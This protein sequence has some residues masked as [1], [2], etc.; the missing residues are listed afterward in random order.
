MSRSESIE[1]KVIQPDAVNTEQ[2]LLLS[3]GEVLNI[4]R[5]SENNLVVDHESVSRKHATLAW[6]HNSI[7]I[8][9]LGSRNGT[10][11]NDKLLV[12]AKQL[13]T[14]DCIEV[15]DIKIIILNKTASINSETRKVASIDAN[16]AIQSRLTERTQ[17]SQLADLNQQRYTTKKAK[18]SSIRK[19]FFL[20][21]GAALGALLAL[22]LS[23][24]IAD[25]SL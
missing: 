12:G 3:K 6:M 19:I 17:I 1:I 24:H 25:I 2:K 9:D 11:V 18:S 15:G 16:Q 8:A 22:L 13:N 21:F 14:G 4:G 10:R 23:G 7:T 20:M 5:S